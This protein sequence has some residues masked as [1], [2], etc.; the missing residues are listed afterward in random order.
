MNNTDILPKNKIE[1]LFMKRLVLITGIIIY[2]LFGISAFF[3]VSAENKARMIE[4]TSVTPTQSATLNQ[5]VKYILKS[6]D[7]KLVVLDYQG[8][9]LEQTDTIVSILP[10]ND[11]KKLESGISVSSDDELRKLLEDLCS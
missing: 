9:I 6:I 5:E 3:G 4:N 1:V 11:R 2:V 7:G 10:E 8:N